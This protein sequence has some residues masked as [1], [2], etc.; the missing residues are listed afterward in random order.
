MPKPIIIIGGAT[1][2]G[3][4]AFSIQLAKAV[5]GSIIN[6]DSMQVYK[7]IPILSAQPSM[8][9]QDNIP[10]YGF[11]YISITSPYSVGLWMEMVEESMHAIDKAG[12][13]PILVGGTGMYLHSLIH[14][15]SPICDI[16]SDIR[17]ESRALMRQLGVEKF[18]QHMQQIDPQAAEKL[19]ANDKQRLIRAY[20]VLQQ[21]GKSIVEW[22]AVPN[23]QLYPKNHFH[24]IWFQPDRETLYDNCN[25]RFEKMLEKGAIEEARKIMQLEPQDE[26]TGMKAL[27]LKPLMEYLQEHITLYEATEVGKTTTRRYAKR[28]TTWFRHQFPADQLLEYSFSINEVVEKIGI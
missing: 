11:G 7:E 8:Q 3:K 5:N 6:A 22:Q 9:E 17:L 19:H 2:S 26:L 23:K 4:T 10:H 24:C 15:L 20:E 1:A 18:Y 12:R 28:Q 13:I 14:G 27:G 16:D 21:T 25:K